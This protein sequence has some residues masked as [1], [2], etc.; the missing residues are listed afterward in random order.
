MNHEARLEAIR[1]VTR[2]NGADTALISHL[3][4]IRWACGFTGSNGLLVVGP[5]QATLLTDGRYASQAPE[6]A[7]AVTVR[8]A[9]AGQNALRTDP[10]LKGAKKLLF[11]ADFVTVSFL[12]RIRA[13]IP[14]VEL[15][16]EIEWLAPLVAQK[17]AEELGSM[18]KAQGITDAVF[19]EVLPL[20]R[21]GVSENDIS[22]EITYRQLKAGAESMPA[23][24][25]PI[26][27][28]GPNSAKPHARASSKKLDLGELVVLDFGCVADGY[29]SDM[30]RTVA[31]GNP[32][33]E[34]RSV[35]EAVKTAQQAA[36]AGARAG[37]TGKALDGLARASLKQ[38][39]YEKYFTHSL[40]HGVG[41][42]VHEWPTVSSRNP[43]PLP[44]GAAV[45]IEPGVYLPGKFGVRIEDTVVLGDGGCEVLGG[46][47]RELIVL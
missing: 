47:D 15:V 44:A 32:G 2:D 42:E 31:L 18:R 9:K 41:L 22:A 21:H 39:S 40:G 34:A 8:I 43:K 1:A 14:G 19:A 6:E 23:D 33:D 7:P 3:P 24:F 36:V 26:V 10:V 20:I 35:Y 5:K 16:G 17:D 46:T 45:T 30:T 27:A 28:S 13:A 4:H 37:V 12:E 25:D 38:A 11:Q 29:C